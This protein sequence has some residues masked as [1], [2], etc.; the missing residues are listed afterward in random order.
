MAFCRWRG[1]ARLPTEAEW[2]FASRGSVAMQIDNLQSVSL[3]PWGNK[4]TPKGKHRYVL[5]RI[6]IVCVFRSVDVCYRLNNRLQSCL[7]IRYYFYHHH[8]LNDCT[9]ASPNPNPNPVCIVL[10]PYPS[11]PFSARTSFKA[12]SLVTTSQRTV[13]SSLVP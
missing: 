13:T 1:G 4:L 5:V 10:L 6:V 11:N 9:N 2:E 7:I 12:R 8:K 3:Y